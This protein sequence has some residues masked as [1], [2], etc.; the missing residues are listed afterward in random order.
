MI[1]EWLKELK[2]GDEVA[3]DFGRYGSSYIKVDKVINITPTGMIDVFGKRFSADGCHG[4]GFDSHFL[5]E[6]TEEL[7]EKYN[8]QEY[9]GLVKAGWENLLGVADPILRRQ[10]T[11]LIKNH[12]KPEKGK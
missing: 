2:V 6:L 12:K 7:R 10:V 5:K 4:K 8:T 3:C 1:N 9:R 11:D